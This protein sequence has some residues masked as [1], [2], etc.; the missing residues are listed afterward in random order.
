[1]IHFGNKVSNRSAIIPSGI[2][3]VEILVV[4]SIIAILSAVI[5]P[6]FLSRPE[7]ARIV[8]A[9]QDIFSLLQALEFYRLDNSIF[10]TTEQGLSA[11]LK[12]PDKS[13]SA[14][15]WTG[16]YIKRL[17]KDPWGNLYL[18]INNGDDIEILSY[19]SD[20][21]A[22]GEGYAEDISSKGL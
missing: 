22:G 2:T 8:A 12:K 14:N 17:K 13:P 9:K 19:G 21:K 4:V 10:P 1:M 7:Q 16:P 6:Q 20:G 11:L 5:V 18:Y 3:L 15:S